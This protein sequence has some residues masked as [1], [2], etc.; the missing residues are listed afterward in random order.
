MVDKFMKNKKPVVH[1]AVLFYESR[2]KQSEI[3]LLE[4]TGNS[5]NDHVVVK[6]DRYED[7]AIFEKAR[8]DKNMQL[9]TPCMYLKKMDEWWVVYNNK[10]IDADVYECYK[11]PVETPKDNLGWLPSD[12]KSG[13]VYHNIKTNIWYAHDGLHWNK[14]DLHGPE[15][16]PNNQCNKGDVIRALNETMQIYIKLQTQL[17][18]PCEVT[19]RKMGELHNTIIKLAKGTND[20]K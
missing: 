12:A 1:K 2:D 4:K 15:P 13:Q 9:Q 8:G 11:D 19:G 17:R 20:D 6:C 18:S 14:I 10:V 3:D 5:L 7:Y 16:V